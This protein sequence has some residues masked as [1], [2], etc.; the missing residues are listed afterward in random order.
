MGHRRPRRRHRGDGRRSRVDPDRALLRR[1]PRIRACRPCPEARSEARPP[2][3]GHRHPRPR[4]ARRGRER[5]DR[6]VVHLLRRADRAAL[7]REP[8]PFRPARARCRGP[9][10][11]RRRGRR[12]PSALPLLPIGRGRCL[13]RD[14]VAAAALRGRPCPDAAGARRALVP[15]VR[16][17]ARPHIEPLSAT[18]SR[19]PS[20]GEDTPFS[21]TPSTRRP[22][23]S[24]P[25]STARSRAPRRPRR[26]SPRTARARR[27]RPTRPRRARP[28][29]VGRRAPSGCRHSRAGPSPPRT[30]RRR[31]PA[32][33]R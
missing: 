18:C 13:R 11:A 29:H 1:P 24:P 19:S 28:R 15:P 27:R 5:A 10:V 9:R 14:G 30:T 7:R 26:R 17:P 23:R 32:R 31:C 25:S 6:Q 16:P 21:G 33:R 22:R 8:A 20:S 12:R 2:R 4:R 3:P